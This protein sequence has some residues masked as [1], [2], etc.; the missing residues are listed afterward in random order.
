MQSLIRTLYDIVLLHRGPEAIPRSW[1]LV[2]AAA[3]LAVLG[4]LAA[5][6]LV[7]PVREEHLFPMLFSLLIGTG[8][9]VTVVVLAGFPE[10]TAPT[11][12]ALLGCFALIQF[13]FVAEWVLF[14]PFVGER[15]TA[16]VAELIQLWSIP[17]EG[18][19]VARAIG[20]HWYVG[21]AIAIG[22]FTLQYI[23]Y[24]VTAATS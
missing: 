11:L 23:L 7:G 3:G 1:L 24:I 5:V 10:R 22:V 18:H 16:I 6:L 2:P 8:L 13:V 12:T 15:L 17:V 21:I 9:Y 20:R 4:E 14:R 19:I